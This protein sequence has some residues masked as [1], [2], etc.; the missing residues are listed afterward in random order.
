MHFCSFDVTTDD[1]DEV[2]ALLKQWTDDGRADDARPKRPSRT[3]PSAAIPMRRRRIPVRRLAFRPSAADPDHRVRPVVLHQGRQGPVRH[4]RQAPRQRWPTCRSSPTRPRP[5]QERRRHLRPG[6]RQRPAG[7]R[8]RH[9]QPGPRR[10]RHRRGAVLAARA[11]AARRRPRANSPRRETCSGSRTEPTTSRPRTPSAL[12]KNVWVADGD[13]PDWLA[14]GT[15]LVTRRIRM[16]I[17]AWD[18]T[19]LLEQE[20]VIGRQKGSGAPNGYADEFDA[21]RLRHQGCQGH[22]ADRRRRP[23]PAG[24][25]PEHVGGIEILRRGYNFTDGSDG[26]GHLD[27]GLFFIAFVRNPDHELHPDAGA[28]VAAT[29]STS[30]S[31]TPARPCSPARRDCARATRRPTG[32]RRCSP[33]RRLGGSSG[34]SGAS[35]ARSGS[36]S[37]AAGSSGPAAARARRPGLDRGPVRAPLLLGHH[38]ELCDVEHLGHVVGPT[39]GAPRPARPCGRCP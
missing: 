38:A 19:T 35:P 29:R 32:A 33:D 24:V 39:A 31:S 17:E 10:V 20:R 11:S 26:F 5:G 1:R 2:V 23:R 9:P 8:A 28:D 36:A 21:A 27:A 18:R 22:P 15:Y 12:D 3:A 7:R 13:G 4:R 34:S 25:G 14:G 16:R 6:M 30:T 37:S